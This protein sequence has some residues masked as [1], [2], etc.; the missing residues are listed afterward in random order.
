ML[1]FSFINGLLSSSPSVFF[2]LNGT[3]NIAYCSKLC[4]YIL[5]FTAYISILIFA[6]HIAVVRKSPG[7][8]VLLCCIS[9]LSQYLIWWTLEFLKWVV[10]SFFKLI[11][12]QYLVCIELIDSA[13]FLFWLLI[14]C[15]SYGA[16][17]LYDQ[18]VVLYCW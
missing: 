2:P 15:V 9:I 4:C 3:W 5:L 8:W 16:W 17:I 14:W 11:S 6:F 12:K 13:R 1:S 7:Q 10:I 18:L